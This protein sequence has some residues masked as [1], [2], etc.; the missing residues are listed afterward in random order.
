MVSIK[1][2][3]Q[4]TARLFAVV[5]AFTLLGAW[6]PVRA[7]DG[8]APDDG[9]YRFVTTSAS[10]IVGTALYANASSLCWKTLDEN[11]L[12]FIWKI[13]KDEN[14]T[15]KAYY[16]MK[17]IVTEGCLGSQD[18]TALYPESQG[19][20]VDLVKQ[21]DGSCLIKCPGKTGDF[22]YIHALGHGNVDNSVG[23]STGWGRL[24]WGFV[25]WRMEPVTGDELSTALSL[26]SRTRELRTKVQDAIA[27]NSKDVT[28]T[29]AQEKANNYAGFFANASMTVEHGI[30]FGSDGGGFEALLDGDVNTFYHSSWKGNPEWSDYEDDGEN[31]VPNNSAVK[32]SHA[33]ETNKQNLGIKLTEPVDNFWYVITERPGEY[34]ATP[35]DI[36][37][38]VSNDRENW[39]RITDSYFNFNVSANGG[40]DIHIGPFKLDSKYRYVRL[41]NN[42][43]YRRSS[44]ASTSY[45]N[46]SEI[47]VYTGTDKLADSNADLTAQMFNALDQTGFVT[48]VNML[49]SVHANLESTYNRVM[50]GIITGDTVVADGYYLLNYANADDPTT[51]WTPIADGETTRLGAYPCDISNPE[52]EYIWHITRLADGN[53]S[54]ANC[55]NTGLPHPESMVDGSAVCNYI[56]MTGRKRQDFRIKLNADG[57]GYVYSA[58]NGNNIA[59]NSET[60]FLGNLK[61]YGKNALVKFVKVEATDAVRL[62]EALSEANGRQFTAGN[63][64]GEVKAEDLAPF[65]AALEAA[66]AESKSPTADIAA[67][68][69]TLVSATGELETKVIPLSDGYYYINSAADASKYLTVAYS[70]GYV[71]P[72]LKAEQNDSPAAMWRITTGADGHKVMKSLAMSDSTYI[73]TNLSTSWTK[74]RMEPVSGSWQTFTNL[75]AN[76]FRISVESGSYFKENYNLWMVTSNEFYPQDN[77]TFI[78]SRVPDNLVPAKASLVETITDA[79]G[80]LASA[81]VG[82]D[83][84]YHSGNDTG[85]KAALKKAE[86]INSASDASAEDVNAAAKELAD[87]TTAFLAE[88]HS[89]IIPVTEDYYRLVS[90]DGP[91]MGSGT[92]AAFAKNGHLFW[93]PLK[94]DDPHFVFKITPQ[95]GGKFYIQSALYDTHFGTVD[96]MVLVTMQNE[97]HAVALTNDEPLL[98]RITNPD[99]G[100]QYVRGGGGDEK[101]AEFRMRAYGS[102]SGS[103]DLRQHNWYLRRLTAGEIAEMHSVG[104]KV[105]VNEALTNAVSRA[106]QAYGNVFRY[107]VDY[108]TP[109]ITNV[110]ADF[111]RDGQVWGMPRNSDK[112]WAGYANLL[113]GNFRCESSDIDNKT[114][115]PLQVDLKDNPI[116]DFEVRYFLR[117]E[118]NWRESWS[119]ITVYSTNDENVAGK[120]TTIAS[121]WNLV[122]QYTDLPVNFG[123]QTDHDQTFKYRVIDADQPYRFYRFVVNSTIMPQT[124]GRFNVM[125]FNMFEIHANEEASPYSYIE[126]MK[127]AADNLHRLTVDAREKLSDGT[128]T[129][130]DVD[131][132][133]AAAKTVEDMTPNATQLANLITEVKNYISS[134]GT[135]DDWG[136]VS[137][138]QYSAILDAVDEADSYDHNNPQISDLATR[139]TALREAFALYKSQQKWPQAGKW[140]RI[141]STDT[142]RPGTLSEGGT[143]DDSQS[144]FGFVQH[145]AI[146]ASRDDKVGSGLTLAGY[147]YLSAA[148]AD[149][150]DGSPYAQ[151]RIAVI[152]SAAG[153]WSLQNRATGLYLGQI[154]PS[155]NKGMQETASPYI[156]TLLKS[157]QLAI[158]SAVDN[159]QH[160]P[161]HGYGSKT[162]GSWTGIT[163]T[164]AADSPSSWTFEEVDES[165]LASLTLNIEDNTMQAVTLPFDYTEDAASLNEE[166]GIMAYSVVGVNEDATELYLTLRNNVPAGEPFLLVANDYTL[167]DDETVVTQLAL[168]FIDGFSRLVKNGN[169][170]VG[171]F[172]DYNPNVDGLGAFGKGGIKA[173][174]KFAVFRTQRA[175]LDLGQV[176]KIA[177]ANIDLTLSIPAGVLNGISNAVTE[178][179]ADNANVYSIDGVLVKKNAKASETTKGLSKGVYIVGGKKVLVK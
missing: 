151:W 96:S 74:L 72:L 65:T 130:N 165:A 157:G 73:Q 60:S 66:E 68:T 164:T 78:V 106:S 47:K 136:D 15:G 148:R 52:E 146:F 18:G 82:T 147:D 33:Y 13:T 175:W 86:E 128:A 88:D 156:L 7:Q 94:K 163:N 171:T 16:Q 1:Q 76:N 179:K 19:L 132:L 142:S 135:D 129:Q 46:I 127:E 43:A 69:E 173:T 50:E 31:T 22:I 14:S 44:K 48:T 133:N 27:R 159:E 32:T 89:R 102:A 100:T 121:E 98:W 166:N 123:R 178:N 93:G 141:I 2:L 5:V 131:A 152:D 99:D 110:N 6:I 91:Y 85:I 117:A 158:T 3:R 139:Y 11:D 161:L 114:G 104:E 122:G 38:E 70:E 71:R 119:D 45:F 118:W 154:I 26:V 108:D 30:T 150:V 124:Y 143:A 138:T 23:G 101:N 169:G 97:P 95:D 81:S 134:Y 34:S 67:V 107:D 24:S 80:A 55:A 77:S 92:P 36:G 53:Y 115:V 87:A 58:K 103:F 75:Y 168:P 41:I 79:R 21:D 61:D 170:L 39:T 149:S 54:I 112:G 51:C 28:P 111:P 120:D 137:E 84:G 10:E 17:N 162:L 29:A 56:Y 90:Q 113:G 160:Y 126:G 25:G 12:S 125:R 63:E 62:S 42:S 37:V 144:H 155:V 83:P 8:N 167:T 4:C 177:D 57:T 59:Y 9:Y 140:Y 20:L 105:K 116:K 64:P 145:E 109:L 172:V 174:D 153:T 49:N 35:T 176:K 40:C